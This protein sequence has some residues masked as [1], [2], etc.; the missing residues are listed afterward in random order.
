MLYPVFGWI[1]KCTLTWPNWGWGGCE[2]FTFQSVNFF[3]YQGILSKKI[4]HKKSGTLT[5]TFYIET[6]CNGL[7]TKNEIIGTAFY[8]ELNF[9]VTI[10]FVSMED[11]ILSIF[12]H[13]EDWESY[14]NYQQSYDFI[15]VCICTSINKVY[16]LHSQCNRFNIYS[17]IY[18]IRSIA[19]TEG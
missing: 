7:V 8:I 10:S 17:M 15:A 14:L 13:L 11:N 19:C 12:S 9:V 3:P 5:T 4:S 16:F 6:F 2:N 18:I 1:W